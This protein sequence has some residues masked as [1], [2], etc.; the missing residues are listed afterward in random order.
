MCNKRGKTAL[1]LACQGR[2]AEAGKVPRAASVAE[3][4]WAHADVN[5]R[6]TLGKSPLL[7]AVTSGEADAYQATQHLLQCKANP[8]IPAVEGAMG[9]STSLHEAA[10]AATIA[11]R[12][13]LELL[14]QS[15]DC[16][17]PSGHFKA[18]WDSAGQQPLHYAA[19]LGDF[20]AMRLLV[21]AR[22]DLNAENGDGDTPI[23]LCNRVG[24]AEGAQY[25]QENGA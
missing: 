18:L 24:E 13:M 3:L 9:R 12:M 20:E 23:A 17:D 16:Y 25:L 2:V 14:L 6:D 5:A 4:L 10:K 11:S 22:A 1:H 8:T 7:N 19:A 15:E 21:E